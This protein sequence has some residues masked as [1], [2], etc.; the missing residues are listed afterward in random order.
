MHF[1]TSTARQHGPCYDSR[2]TNVIIGWISVSIS[3][4]VKTTYIWQP[5]N[6]IIIILLIQCCNDIEKHD[7]VGYIINPFKSNQ[8]LTL[9]KRHVWHCSNFDPTLLCL[10]G[11]VNY[12]FALSKTQASMESIPKCVSG[13]DIINRCNIYPF[14]LLR[15]IQ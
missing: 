12:F 6:A 1:R 5:K 10:Q 4:D 13:A 7:F 8:N 3:H 15:W 2:W 14:Y 11:S 9:F